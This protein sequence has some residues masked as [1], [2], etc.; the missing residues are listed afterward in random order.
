M[1]SQ[2]YGG[3]NMKNK[4]LLFTL[5][6]ALVITTNVFAID[7]TINNDQVTF[8]NVDYQKSEN[9]RVVVEG[10]QIQFDV[11]PQIINGRTLVPMRAIFEAIGLAVDWDNE[12]RVA[13]GTNENISIELK[14]D[15][16]KAIVNMEEKVLDVPAS[17][18]AGRTMVPLRFLS[19]SIGYNV[20]WVGNSNLILISKSDII[21]WRYEGYENIS[22]YKEYEVKYVNGLRTSET[23]YNGK[24]H[25]VQEDWRYEGYEKVPP[26][27]EYE[28]KYV[29]GLRTNE[30]R[31][32][33]KNHSFAVDK[34]GIR[35][36]SI[37]V[38]MNSAGGASPTIIW[39]NDS[40]K[41]I[42]YVYF[43]VVPYNAV[44]DAMSCTITEKSTAKLQVTGPVVPFNNETD[45]YNS[46]FEYSN[47][48][49]SVSKDS[50]G[51]YYVEH[52]TGE[53]YYLT[54]SDYN[55]CFNITTDWEPVWYNSTIQTAN[56]TNVKIEYMDGTTE[57]ISYPTIF[58]REIRN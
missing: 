48:I 47:S 49:P 51:L 20:V 34:Q 33:G 2:K 35:I 37:Y 22:P 9:I 13:K 21:E 42:K 39:R 44:G 15:S 28:V 18:I 58:I 43:T 41:N 8:E 56:I 24:N 26:Y 14:I 54:Q 53:K 27:K 45:I 12:N 38:R 50:S 16:N 7:F 36:L 3:S 1:S 17:I 23:R 6:L 5:F 57:T 19:E 25:A 55:N 31:Y 10:T 32:N 52:W 30:T 4:I 29:N 46:C 11:N 40:S